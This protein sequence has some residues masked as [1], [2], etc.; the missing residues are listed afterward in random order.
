MDLKLSIHTFIHIHTFK[1]KSDYI[2]PCASHC[3]N[4]GKC[5][6]ITGNTYGCVCREEYTGT[7]CETSILGKRIV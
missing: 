5:E 1:T 4:G 2:V 6:L 3:E 7:R